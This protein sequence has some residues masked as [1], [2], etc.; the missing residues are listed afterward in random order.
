MTPRARA[1]AAEG[2]AVIQSDVD[3]ADYPDAAFGYVI[4]SPT[5]RATRH[6]RQVLEHMPR[7]GRRAIVSFRLFGHWR[8]DLRSA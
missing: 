3:L 7:I 8:C 1:G 5:L 4:L 2:L 6:P